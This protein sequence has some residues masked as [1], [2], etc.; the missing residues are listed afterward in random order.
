MEARNPKIP[1][2]F[3]IRG[4]WFSQ[5]TLG[6][7]RAWAPTSSFALTHHCVIDAVAKNRDVWRSVGI[8]LLWLLV[9]WCDKIMSGIP[10]I[11]RGWGDPPYP[12][13]HLLSLVSCLPSL[14]LVVCRLPTSSPPSLPLLH[15]NPGGEGWGWSPAGVEDGRWAVRGE[16]DCKEGWRM[17][18]GRRGVS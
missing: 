15:S 8:F 13:S 2:M 10:N 17:T 7:Y 11:L 5:T 1:G 18:A 3:D 12:I 9:R 16:F 14:V 4:R 6:T